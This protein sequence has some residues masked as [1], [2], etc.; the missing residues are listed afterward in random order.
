MKEKEVEAI[1]LCIS[2]EKENRDYSGT[3]EDT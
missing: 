1:V 3:A 2:E